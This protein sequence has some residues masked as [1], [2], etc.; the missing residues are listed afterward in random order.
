MDQIQKEAKQIQKEIPEKYGEIIDNDIVWEDFLR[1][2][3]H[4]I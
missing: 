1:I 2:E 3:S 4:M